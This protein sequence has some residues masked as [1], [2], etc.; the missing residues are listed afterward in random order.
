[1]TFSI[2]FWI[3]KNYKKYLQTFHIAPSRNFLP[4]L[5]LSSYFLWKKSF[6]L[7]LY[8]SY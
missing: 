1:M 7:F 4:F 2:R 6:R 5:L 3:E 8:S